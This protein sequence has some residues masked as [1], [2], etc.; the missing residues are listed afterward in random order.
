M[1]HKAP[2]TVIAMLRLSFDWLSNKKNAA[3]HADT[4]LHN[5]GFLFYLWYKL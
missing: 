3:G 5:Q 1:I 2:I 4:K